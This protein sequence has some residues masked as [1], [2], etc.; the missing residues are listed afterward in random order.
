MG[1]PR[2]D[3]CSIKCMASWFSQKERRPNFFWDAVRWLSFWFIG[4]KEIE[5]LKIIEM[6]GLWDRVKFFSALCGSVS[7]D[8]KDCIL[9]CILL[10][11]KAGVV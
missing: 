5:F 11:W 10:D 7:I 8:F 1:D 2:K 6:Q 3:S 9:F 4:W